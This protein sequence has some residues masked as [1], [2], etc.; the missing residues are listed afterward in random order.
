[1]KKIMTH[2]ILLGVILCLGAW[3]CGE[4]VLAQ[5]STLEVETLM[6]SARYTNT[7][8][9][10]DLAQPLQ[11]GGQIGAAYLVGTEAQSALDLVGAD[12]S[13]LY[14]DQN[15]RLV[16]QDFRYSQEQQIRIARFSLLEGIMT[17]EAKHL[18]YP[19]NV[20]EV[21]TPSVVA[22]FRFSIATF[23]VDSNGNT[24]IDGADGIINLST[25]GVENPN[26]DTIVSYTLPN[27]VV[28][29]FTI[30]RGGEVDFEVDDDGN[31]F[32]TN[33]GTEDLTIVNI[34]GNTVVM[35]PG[36]SISV[37]GTGTPESPTVTVTNIGTIDVTVG[38]D[39]MRANESA[40]SGPDDLAG[41][42]PS[43]GVGA[44][45]RDF[46]DTDG[47]G[48]GGVGSPIQP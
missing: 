6:G 43:T 27:E 5:E 11:V 40:V 38:N 21:E 1:M 25:S 28:I 22:A 9:D 34:R 48:G 3:Y 26:A 8:K 39:I 42:V 45:G 2:G 18:D 46:G 17:A 31:V 33:K 41:F 47:D 20:F 36:A 16:V 19:S 7:L 44:V 30:P 10:P 12:G 13:V 15:T 24:N 29:E 37:T 35:P 32:I 23:K 14:V 4:E